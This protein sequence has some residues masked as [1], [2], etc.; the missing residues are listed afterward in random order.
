MKAQRDNGHYVCACGS[1][2]ADAREI[3]KQGFDVFTHN[4]KRTINPF[5]IVITVVRLRR[6]IKE[7]NIDVLICHTPLGGFLGRLA[8]YLAGVDC[9]I[10]FAHGLLCAPAQSKVK[11]LIFFLIEKS[12]AGLANAFIVMN[13]Y[14][15]NLSRTRLAGKAKVFRIAGMGVD[16]N[17]FSDTNTEREKAS[18]KNE[19]SISPSD[20]I[21]LSVAFLISEKGIWDF[22]EAAKII[23]SRRSDVCFMIAGSGPDEEN[24]VNAV[25]QE[26]LSSQFRVLGWRTDVQRLMKACDIFVLPSY[27]FEGLPVSILEAMACKK[28]VIS[29]FHRGC[30]DTVSNEETGLLVPIKSPYELSNAIIKLLNDRKLCESMGRKGREKIESVFEIGKCT[31]EITD[32][33]DSI[34]SCKSSRSSGSF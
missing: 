33:I 32:I 12:L 17:R 22:F 21:M 26:G 10:Y 20:K 8:G 11:W 18:V 34:I 31:K 24:L 2:D 5:S 15:E 3:K 7:N 14:D 23:C 28:P 4:L 6:I 29:T 19:F 9:V 30:E 13:D 16:I 1:D 25:K 27:Y